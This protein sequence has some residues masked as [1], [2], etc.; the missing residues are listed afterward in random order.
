MT[1]VVAGDIQMACLPAQGAIGQV[2]AGTVV[3]LAV[4]TANRAAA[5]PNVPALRE[6]YPDIVGS[7]WIGFVGPAGLP[8][9]LAQRISV[10]IGEALRQPEA[11]QLLRKQFMEVAA[12]PPAEFK[13]FMDQEL[14]RW[15]SVIEKN[16]ITAE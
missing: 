11:V 10:A 13:T 1:A 7:A 15:K 4:S 3:P 8:Q 16:H 14:A 12:G 2:E 9:P 5:L 6:F